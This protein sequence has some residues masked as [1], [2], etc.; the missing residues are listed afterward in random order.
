DILGIS[1]EGFGS[2]DRSMDAYLDHQFSIEGLM[3]KDLQTLPTKSTVA[4][5]AEALSDGSIHAVPVVDDK[6]DLVGL[7]TSTDLIRFLRDLF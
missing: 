4:D 3:K 7:V 6:G 2:D 5:A 1:V